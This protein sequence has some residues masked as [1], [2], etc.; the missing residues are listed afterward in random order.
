MFR[1]QQGQAQIKQVGAR[2]QMNTKQNVD[3]HKAKRRGQRQQGQ[4]QSQRQQGNQR[5][6]REASLGSAVNGSPM[7]GVINICEI[8]FAIYFPKIWS[9]NADLARNVGV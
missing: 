9:T 3:D 2:G 1:R 4:R 7:P 6:Y 5:R 8:S